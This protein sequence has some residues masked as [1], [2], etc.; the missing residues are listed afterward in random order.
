[1]MQGFNVG[2]LTGTGLL[3]YIALKLTN[4]NNIANVLK[5]SCPLFKANGLPIK[6]IK[7]NKKGLCSE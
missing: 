4:F 2:D 7:I 3:F 6:R 5:N 1:M